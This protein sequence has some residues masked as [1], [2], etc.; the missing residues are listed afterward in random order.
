M[1]CVFCCYQLGMFRMFSH[2]LLSIVLQLVQNLGEFS[3]KSPIYEHIGAG[4]DQSTSDAL[5][6]VIASSE[7]TSE[8]ENSVQKL[9]AKASREEN[10]K[11]QN[12]VAIQ[13]FATAQAICNQ[14]EYDNHVLNWAM[15]W[16]QAVTERIDKELVK[17]RKL[18]G[19]RDHYEKKVELLRKRFNEV[20]SKGKSSPKGQV[21][22]LERNEGKLKEAFTAHEAAAGR[23]CAL[24]EVATRD[25]WIELY[26]LCR[27]YM[28][29]ESNRG[30]Y[31][32]NLREA[33]NGV[34]D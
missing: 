16:E 31:D 21:V 7:V 23:L 13:Q 29:W 9:M 26:T 27:N 4:L 15:E 6:Q 12:L 1:K 34:S 25:G 28:K 18:Q 22:K 24:M 19:D 14:R 30:A 2:E 8:K 20:E 3:Q 5:A 32:V 10:D 17:V 11:L 33:S